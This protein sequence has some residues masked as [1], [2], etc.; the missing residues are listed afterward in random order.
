[1]GQAQQA[2]AAF[3]N[4]RAASNESRST[5]KTLLERLASR[6]SE[7]IVIAFA[8]PVGC[9][10]EDVLDA[11]EQSLIGLGYQVVWLKLS[12]CL[13][14]A[15]S[16]G[17]LVVGSPAGSPSFVRSRRLQAAALRMREASGD[18]HVLAEFAVE[19]VVV[20]R[21]RAAIS[22][23]EVRPV[24]RRVAYLLDQ[25][26]RPEEVELL[27]TMYR[28][29]FYL[30]GVTRPYAQRLQTLRER[31]MSDL[32]AA[33]LIAMDR[34]E[35]ETAGQRLDRTLH[36]SDVFVRNDIGALPTATIDRFMRL[37]HGDRALSP[38][39]DEI[40]MYAAFAAGLKSGCLSRQVG[41][42]ITNE[43]GDVLSTGCNDA[44]AP[45][46]GLHPRKGAPDWRCM[47]LGS[48][49][50]HNDIHK[51]H[52]QSEIGSVMRRVF[53]SEGCAVPQ[54][55]MDR[56]MD[57]IYEDTRVGGLIEF[58]RAVH[59]EMDAIL[60]M[61]RTATQGLVGATLYTTT[62]PCHSCARHIVAAGIERVVYIEPY[63]KSLA[64]ELH[65]DAITF[66]SMPERDSDLGTAEPTTADQR[67]RFEH[68]EGLA[69]RLFPVVF[70][71]SGRK[72]VRSGAF[73]PLRD[74]A[75]G[76][77]LPEYMDNYTE[78]ETAAST[79]FQKAY[80]HACNGR[81]PQVVQPRGEA[82]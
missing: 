44:P 81:A 28:N 69:P 23:S 77:V 56:A 76:K 7:E 2:A 70:R 80:R 68:F 43:A 24:P 29:L 55:A 33:T 74:S 27:R 35:P 36:L 75:P 66:E 63:D 12:A 52:L 1:M 73:I 5:S 82:T 17:H 71:S 20:E 21:S 15:L 39:R 48:R 10:L 40:G 14:S 78:F 18:L 34:H 50:C 47:H 19:R 31:G 26:K 57:A 53:H 79:H 16:A 8:G 11:T 58:S 25:L 9:G 42:A 61:A 54:A 13:E 62:F 65:R 67:V 59:A 3:E 72:D 6:Q 30:V 60:A 46:G 37:I 4:E 51:R 64:Q 22:D 45:G 38:S 32:E 49:S 41:A